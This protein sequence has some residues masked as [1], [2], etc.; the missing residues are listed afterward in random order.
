MSLP[1][2]SHAAAWVTL[3]LMLSAL[4][5]S[6]ALLMERLGRGVVPMRIIWG[7]AL[8]TLL[9]LAIAAPLRVPASAPTPPG[10]LAPTQTV[11]ETQPAATLSSTPWQALTAALR[12]GST[13]LSDASAY[14]AASV[15]TAVPA[16]M[17]RRMLPWLLGLWGIASAGV[18]VVLLVAYRRLVRR[19]DRGVPQMLQGVP[20]VVTD[21]IG[22]LVAGVRSPRIAVPR[23]LLARTADEQGLVLAHEQAHLA[24]RDPLLLIAGAAGTVLMPWNPFSW[25]LLARLRLAIEVDCDQRVLRLGA[26]TGRY[27]RLLI[28]LAATA[29][30]L[31]LSAPAFSYH[32][33][34]LER[35]LRTMTTPA[36]RFRSVRRVPL[37]GAAALALLTACE[38]KLPTAT[39]VERMDVAALEARTAAAL[40]KGADTPT[41]FFVNGRELTEAEAKA[42]PAGKIASIQI[43]K[44]SNTVN[45]VRITTGGDT[46]RTARV[47]QGRPLDSGTV[48]ITRLTDTFTDTLTGKVAVYV[49]SAHIRSNRTDTAISPTAVQNVRIGIRRPSSGDTSSA[50]VVAKGTALGPNEQ[51]LFIVDGVRATQDALNRFTPDQILSIEV[52]KGPTAATLY[53]P[54]GAK[55]VIVITTKGKK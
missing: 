53:G 34:H 9:A 48:N 44:G 40:P 46:L 50:V 29:P 10:G 38:S 31:P 2:L 14:V 18:L 55:G 32:T 27:G 15:T 23:W 12:Q 54:D 5:Y 6:A 1:T 11:T 41:R 4:L 7:G 17:A 21:D 25:A 19:I 36:P 52:I 20:V 30:R 28:D 26:S 35:R 13:S 51:P 8:L 42:L 49:D 47:V 16:P 3:V 33:T 39:E 37:V 45:E 24:A 43:T 22:P